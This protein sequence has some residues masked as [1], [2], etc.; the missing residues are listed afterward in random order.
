MPFLATL[1][2]AFQIMQSPSMPIFEESFT[3]PPPADSMSYNAAARFLEQ[4]TFG[5]S[6]SG[7]SYLI[8]AGLDQW[9]REQFDAA[10]SPV[11]DAPAGI[12]NHSTVQ[13]D[14]FDN[15][16]NRDD[17]LRQRV[18]F[19]LGQIWV[20]SGVK[21]NRPEAFIPYLRMLQKDVFGNYYDLIYDVT[22]SPAM[23]RYLDMVNNDKANP[24]L[25]R[26]PN[27]N[28]ARGLLQLFTTGLEKLNED[29]SVVRDED[30][31]AV[32]AYDQE[33]IEEL[34]RAF[35][36]LD[37]P[38][39]AWTGVARSQSRVLRRPDGRLQQQPRYRCQVAAR[40]P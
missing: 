22:L 27:E 26:S 4:A 12:T 23:G 30:G 6:P 15:A 11:P 14:F 31:Q 2:V 28:Y 13:Q 34:A 32:P 8:G 16:I 24:A 25:G 18:A 3:D 35:N 9:L 5:P 21:I 38:A 33:V 17:Q 39:G 19:A 37:L 40:R 7:I 20:I 10:P 36:L 29:G 1:L